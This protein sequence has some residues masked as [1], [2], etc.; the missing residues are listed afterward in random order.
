MINRIIIE[1]KHSTPEHEWSHMF[2][3]PLRY[4]TH[5]LAT[6]SLLLGGAC[7]ETNLAAQRATV[8]DEHVISIEGNEK[9]NNQKQ[10]LLLL[11]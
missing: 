3:Q 5:T 8:P 11:L 2:A 4:C 9:E 7:Q 1:A 10:C 6:F